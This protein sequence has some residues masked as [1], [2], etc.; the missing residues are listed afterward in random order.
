MVV[1][2]FENLDLYFSKESRFIKLY[3]MQGILAVYSRMESIR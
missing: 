1:D 2:K 3:V